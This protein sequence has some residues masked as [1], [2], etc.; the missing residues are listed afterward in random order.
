MAKSITSLAVG[1]AVADG[2]LDVDDRVPEPPP[3]G[4]K[5]ADK[6]TI[7]EDTD[8][9]GRADKAKDF[10]TELNLAS[11]LAIGNGGVYVGQ[12]PYLLF[13]PDRNGDDVPD[14]DPEKIEDT[15]RQGGP[16]A[17][18]EPGM[19]LPEV[20]FQDAPVVV[21]AEGALGPVRMARAVYSGGV[22]G[23][24]PWRRLRRHSGNNTMSL[25]IQYEAIIRWLPA[26]RLIVRWNSWFSRCCS[27]RL[28]A[29]D[30]RSTPLAP[31]G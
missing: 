6:I 7:L 9:D 16:A 22:V 29:W 13:Y 26:A 10:A 4:P 30:M 11:A 5:G 20:G 14:G 2:L 8:G 18:G 25:G 19:E 31:S 3:R 1:V 23:S 12:A 24:D 27:S 17:V 15:G 28:S 21:L